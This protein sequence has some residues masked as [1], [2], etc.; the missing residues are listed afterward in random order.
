[1]KK[2]LCLLVCFIG[3]THCASTGLHKD[4]VIAQTALS[5]AKKFQANTFFPS[6][7]NKADNLYRK[8]VSFY[9]QKNYEESQTLF[10]E[11]IKWAEKAEL[12]ARLKLAKEEM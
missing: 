1:M 12:K 5:R 11:S 9:N 4:F 6:A 2:C 3:L 7:Y 8:A 10:Q